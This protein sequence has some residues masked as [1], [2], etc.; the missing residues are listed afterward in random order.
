MG[1]DNTKVVWPLLKLC[2]CVSWRVILAF[3]DNW[4][5]TGGVDEYVKWTGD[6]TKT[7]K[8]FYTD[9]IIMG[10]CAVLA[11]QHLTICLLD[12]KVSCHELS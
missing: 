5:Q 7:H 3:V 6:A 8:D 10:W 12:E 11:A 1:V 9:P 2:G 4:Q